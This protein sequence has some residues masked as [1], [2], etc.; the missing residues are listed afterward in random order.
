MYSM[1]FMPY[2]TSRNN[3][4]THKKR[5]FLYVYAPLPYTHHVQMGKYSEKRPVAVRTLR[6]VP[7][8]IIH[9][10]NKRQRTRR[11]RWWWKKTFFLSKLHWWNCSLLQSLKIIR[12]QLE[13]CAYRRSYLCVGV[14][15]QENAMEFGFCVRMC[16]E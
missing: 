1:W 6:I 13:Y 11:R 4:S 3:V 16:V 15:H 9:K 2:T 14:W 8:G 5:K 12:I 7:Y 10:E